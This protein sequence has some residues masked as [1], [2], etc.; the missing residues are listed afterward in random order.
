MRSRPLLRRDKRLVIF[1]A[2]TGSTGGFYPGPVVLIGMDNSTKPSKSRLSGALGV[3]HLR[4]NAGQASIVP[5]T[6]CNLNKAPV[7]QT[8]LGPFLRLPHGGFR[9][10]GNRSGRH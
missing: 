4:S 2:I 8:F 1:P 5:V 6:R 3:K 10:P 7:S 9:I